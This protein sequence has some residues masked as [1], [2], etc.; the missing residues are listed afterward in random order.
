M[1]RHCFIM[2]SLPVLGLLPRLAHAQTCDL[3]WSDQFP[4]GHVNSLV[5]TL[6]VF[7]PDANGPNPPALHLGGTFTVAGGVS[8]LRVAQW[9]GYTWSPLGLGTTGT[10]FALAVWDDDGDG[11]NPPALYAAGDFLSAGGFSAYRIAKW[12]GVG[13]SSVGGGTNSTVYALAVFDDDIGDSEPPA[14]FAGGYFTTAGGISAKRIA[15]W[16]GTNWSALNEGVG[17]YVNAL[18]V[19]D[20]D[21]TGPNEAAL[22][23]GGGFTTADGHEANRIATW[24]GK[25]WHAL[26]TSTGENGV[27]GTVYD[28]TVFDDDDGGPNL[29]ML[30]VG[31]SFTG[32]GTATANR[33]AKWDGSDFYALGDGM[34]GSVRA[35][36][37]FDD[38]DAGPN[39]PALYAGGSFTAAGGGAA[40]RI[41][42]WD[43]STWSALE[44]GLDDTVRALATYD[45]LRDGS[46]PTA[47]F[48][49]GAFTEA[50]GIPSSRIGRWGCPPVDAPPTIVM[51]PESQIAC[52]DGIA[53]FTVAATGTKPLAYQ[54]YK[55]G[56]L[57][58]G[59]VDSSYTI[60]PVIIDDVGVYEVV[61]ANLFGDAT[62]DPA[63]LTLGESPTISE[64]PQ[65]ET[66]CPGDGVIFTVTADGTGSLSYQWK[67]NGAVI[68]GA[69]L[70]FL[71]IDNIDSGDEGEYTVVVTGDCGA[72]TSDAAVLTMDTGPTITTQPQSATP[73]EGDA[74]T[75]TVSAA[76]AK[77]FSYQWRHDGQLIVGATGASLI[78]DPVD[79]G[80]EGDYQVVVSTLC[81]SATSDTATLTV[82]PAPII[83]EHP[84]TQV[85]CEGGAVTFTV[86]A[87][88]EPPLSYQWRK[89]GQPIDGAIDTWYAID[90]VGPGDVGQYDVVV[91]GA[92]GATTSD[93]AS[94]STTT[95]PTITTQPLPASVCAGDAVSFS[96]AADGA[97]IL[98]YQW[99]KD[100]QPIAG[101]T[102]PSYAIDP[103][104]AADAGTYDVLVTDDCGSVTSDAAAL[105]VDAGPG[106]TAQ[107]Q[108]QAA[109]VGG[110]VTFSV[111]AGGTEPIGYQWRKDAQP[112]DGATAASYA[113]D[114]VAAE[115]AGQYDVVVSNP[116]GSVTSDA[117]A[118]TID[119]N[120]TITS[121]PQSQ[122]VCTG[123]SVTFTA[124]AD[125]AAP[126]EY[127]WHK[128]GQP[129][130]GATDASYTIDSVATDHAGDYTA[131]VS[132]ACETVTSEVATL[133]VSAGPTITA[134]P[135]ARAACDGAAVTFSVT[136][137]GAEPLTY[138]WRKDAQP[139]DGA[140][141][142]SYTIAAVV[143]DDAGNY[144]VVV[145]NTCGTLTSDAA[146]LTVDAGPAITSQ[147]QSQSACT[148]GT[149]T[150]TVVA[151]GTP[152][153]TYQWRFDGQPIDGATAD[154]Y[155][156]DPIAEA[157][158]GQYDVVVT[159][160]CGA[161]TSDPAVLAVDGGPIIS[162]QP[163]AQT[164]CDGDTV[165][166]SVVADGVEPL[167]YQWR[168]D[169][170]PIDDAIA[171]TYAIDTA[172]PADAGNYDAVVTGP[173]G[174]T[175][176][177]VATLTV[178]ACIT[179]PAAP[180]Q[181]DPA[182]GDESVAVDGE[183]SWAPADGAASYDV[184]LGTATPPA[185]AGNATA[186][187]WSVVGLANDTIYYWQVAAR[188]EAGTT[189]G[190][191]WSFTTVAANNG[192]G[193]T[194]P[195]VDPG[196]DPVD[197][198]PPDDNDPPDTDVNGTVQVNDEVPEDVLPPGCGAGGCGVGFAGMMPL[199]LFCLCSLKLKLPRRGKRTGRR[200]AER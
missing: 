69:T 68:F 130:D 67:K 61:V 51:Q 90:P 171:A 180:T 15:K 102:E 164:V 104:V 148:G 60:D 75:L 129:I 100:G 19:F 44:G 194:T 70:D 122:S 49:G 150:F 36:A 47:L 58:D 33:I 63:V 153:I 187:S 162:T 136:A 108:P 73:C 200:R 111:A 112:I 116:C 62:S 191:I 79:L 39:A 125:G 71:F 168:K 41:A 21:D 5:H 76:G 27:D 142:A 149:A 144:D 152:P 23:V 12:D 10:V 113:I 99:Y 25:S 114:P 16:D 56:A 174:S 140:T 124:D 93:A 172:S 126:L 132:N 84:Q 135:Q 188:N 115:D 146:A 80:D 190:P 110:A 31:G 166:L 85:A 86:T 65:S 59:A 175:T 54:W 38:D 186:T 87:D 52:P 20:D 11:P 131:V 98:D 167:T 138:Q 155:T 18:T 182:D 83:T 177:D 9:N 2:L 189:A 78:I 45:N 92:C 121:Q 196:N 46:S 66:A 169:G 17:N 81:G 158:A 139:I 13:W 161:I 7:D 64:Q 24:T 91:T 128:D 151:N 163:E 127:A 29:P 184:Y 96:V 109:C 3:E 145:E 107:P 119:A 34:D 134:Q 35:L 106:I 156:I 1:L 50:D 179:A 181:P 176:S 195:P 103:V 183:L 147:P 143:A 30:Y 89:D 28:M 48:V 199:T 185:L 101:A 120:P 97:G 173:C 154:S 170:Q 193:V 123:A 95:G 53:V 14:L 40:N 105:T 159:H 94:L 160:A 137:A 178:D 88:G 72:T 77:P 6:T 57:I 192:G 43:G 118:L 197:P 32:A 82:A 141:A 55:D 8:A 157:D 22:Y 4:A 42:R 74:V 133:T 165:T 26:V 117:V 198:D 37:V